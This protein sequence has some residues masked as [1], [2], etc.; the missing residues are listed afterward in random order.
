[1][2]IKQRNARAKKVTNQKLALREKL[3]GQ[4]NESE[5]WNRKVNDGYTTIPR[6]FPLIAQIM[7]N[8]SGKGTPVSNTYL[9]IWCRVFD[10][11]FIEIE[12]PAILAMESGFSGQRAITTWNSRMS[13][14]A[15]LGF[16][17]PERG[18][19]GDYQY[20]LVYNPYKIIQKYHEE[21]N[22]SKQL[23]LALF[24]RA[25]EIGA[26]DLSSE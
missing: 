8:L 17:K 1:M 14:L 5:L 13:K 21:D 19:L 4:I 16:I 23:Y 24:K 10:E 11:S 7:D 15:Q 6:T 2:N 18:T 25:Q 20:V 12:T 9:T 26:D 3:W 22:I